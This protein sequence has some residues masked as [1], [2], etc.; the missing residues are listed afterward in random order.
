MKKIFLGVV[1]LLII[2]TSIAF[3][4]VRSSAK[5]A[6]A[7]PKIG[8]GLYGGMPALK[9]NLSDV[10]S[11]RFG[12]SLST[13]SGDARNYDSAFSFLMGGDYNIFKIRNVDI[14]VGGFIQYSSVSPGSVSYF[15][16]GGEWGVEAVITP[17]FSV[18]LD[19]YPLTFTSISAGGVSATS[20]DLGSGVLS[21][22][23][24]F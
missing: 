20:L 21:A 11:L 23:Y 10:F 18:G 16:L 1:V 8:L 24:Y 3:A 14:H 17:N 2:S 19:L 15:T 5:V 9:M 4:Q 7:Y 13:Q 12:L 22:Y 6:S